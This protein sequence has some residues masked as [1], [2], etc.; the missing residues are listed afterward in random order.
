MAEVCLSMS[1]KRK[2]MTKWLKL[3]G[4]DCKIRSIASSRSRGKPNRSRLSTYPIIL[5][6]WGPT[7]LSLKRGLRGIKPFMLS[8]LLIKSR[9]VFDH[10]ERNHV[11]CCFCSSAVIVATCKNDTSDF[12]DIIE[13]FTISI[14]LSPKR[15]VKHI[16]L[17]FM[18]E[19]NPQVSV[20]V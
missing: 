10:I 9:K 18:F 11:L 2:F 1:F 12:H 7:Q 17:L 5:S 13:M 16:Q 14:P 19:D 6:I 15:L 20:P 4:N 8:M 3:S